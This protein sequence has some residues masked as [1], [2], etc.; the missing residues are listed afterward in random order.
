[1]LVGTPMGSPSDVAL[2]DVERDDGVPE[3]AIGSIPV[4]TRAELLAYVAKVDDH[5]SARGR[6]SGGRVFLSD[7]G[8]AGGDFAA[9]TVNRSPAWAAAWPSGR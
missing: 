7:N 4:T 9:D 1:M 3:F 8:D 5:E 6:G 2:A